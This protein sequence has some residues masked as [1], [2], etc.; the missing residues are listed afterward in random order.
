MA[1]PAHAGSATIIAA[2]RIGLRIASIGSRYACAEEVERE[3]AGG[4]AE[5]LRVGGLNGQ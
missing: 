1:H 3:R 2:R 5:D 4:N